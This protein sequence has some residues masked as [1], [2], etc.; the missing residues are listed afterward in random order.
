M[1]GI[2]ITPLGEVN[3]IEVGS[4]ESVIEDDIE[5]YGVFVEQNVIVYGGANGRSRG[6]PYNQY[7]AVIFK[8]LYGWEQT[9]M[10]S[11][12]KYGYPTLGN[13]LVLGVYGSNESDVP[14]TFVEMAKAKVKA[15]NA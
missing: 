8:D 7:A 9:A 3:E 2:L 6:D 12:E 11:S 1:K 4:L 13:V 10:G 5:V 15:F 14:S